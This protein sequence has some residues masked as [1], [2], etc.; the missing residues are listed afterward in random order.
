MFMMACRMRKFNG[1]KYVYIKK[2]YILL[3]QL[4]ESLL[5]VTY[6]GAQGDMDKFYRECLMSIDVVVIPSIN[7]LS[8][9]ITPYVSNTCLYVQ[10][11]VLDNFSAFHL[12]ITTK[13]G[14][15]M[16]NFTGIINQYGAIFREV[17]LKLL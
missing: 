10:C 15:M 17:Q 14:Y 8:Q 11:R 13:P 1:I 16:C 3:L 4:I 9:S 2:F 12:N 5:K 7:I 6:T